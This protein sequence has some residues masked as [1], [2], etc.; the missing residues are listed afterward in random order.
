MLIAVA[1]FNIVLY[2][3]VKQYYAWRNRS[4]ARKWAQLSAGEQREYLETTMSEG[5]QKLSFRFVH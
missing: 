3:A 5:N 1:V 4:R 2:A